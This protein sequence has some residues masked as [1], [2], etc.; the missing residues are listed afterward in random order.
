VVG[1][2]RVH[3][4]EEVKPGETVYQWLYGAHLHPLSSYLTVWAILLRFV[5]A[6]T[7]GKEH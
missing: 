6:V 1:F 3:A 4:E 7:L 5:L 2:L